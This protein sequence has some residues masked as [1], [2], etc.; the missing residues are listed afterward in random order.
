MLFIFENAFVSRTMAFPSVHA[1]SVHLFV[2]RF[3]ILPS[4]LMIYF[5]CS[6]FFRPGC[7]DAFVIRFMLFSIQTPMLLLSRWADA[8]VARYDFV[9][10]MIFPSRLLLPCSFFYVDDELMIWLPV[11]AFCVHADAFSV[12]VRLMLLL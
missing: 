1:F 8:F 12:H 3:M 6:C 4:T 7:A 10:F 5:P 9:A 11:H 2:A